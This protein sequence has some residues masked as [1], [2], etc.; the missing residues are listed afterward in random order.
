MKGT[1]W[2]AGFSEPQLEGIKQRL[3][4]IVKSAVQFDMLRDDS[5]I[6]GFIAHIDGVAY[7]ASL[8]SRLKGIRSAMNG[9]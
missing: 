8:R 1:I 2:Y 6:G 9:D 3:E 7:D 4:G 5:L